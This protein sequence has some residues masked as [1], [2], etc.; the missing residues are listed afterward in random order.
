[1]SLKSPYFLPKIPNHKNFK[2]IHRNPADKIGQN[3]EIP[4]SAQNLAIKANCENKRS[5]YPFSLWLSFPCPRVFPFRRCCCSH[6]DKELCRHQVIPSRKIPWFYSSENSRINTYFMVRFAGTSISCTRSCPTTSC[7]C[8]RL[9]R[10]VSTRTIPQLM[11]HQPPQAP[12]YPAAAKDWLRMW[13]EKL[14]A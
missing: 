14:R 2:K 11:V 12:Q 9:W 1:M 7:L 6:A 8:C 5:N 13:M 3:T 10:S 4:D